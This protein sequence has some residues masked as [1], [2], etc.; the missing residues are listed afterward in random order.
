MQRAWGIFVLQDS[1]LTGLRQ[2]YW[3]PIEN[4]VFAVVK[5]LL[6]FVIAGAMPRYGIFTSWSIPLVLSLIPV[7]ILIFGRLMPQ[8]EAATA[9]RSLAMTMPQLM[10]FVGADYIGGLFSLMATALLPII[11]HDQAGASM[12]AYFYQP[13]MI[14]S[15]LQIVTVNL[16]A[17]MT[18]EA[19]TEQQNVHLFGRRVLR[20]GA[21]I[22]VPIVGVILI[23]APFLLRI[24]GAA[25]ATEGTTLLRLLALAVL[26][27]LVNMLF[28]GIARVQ[29]RMG[30]L[31]AIQ[32]SLC[33]IGLAL[34]LLL[35]PRYGITG[36]GIAWLVGQGV[37]AVVLLVTQRFTLRRPESSRSSD[38]DR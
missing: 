19:A 37:V 16:A 13:W 18:V 12:N 22:L 3:V 21:M 29:K 35:L 17:S 10:R 25:Y 28:I 8:H 20:H 5:L 24:F 31:I 9:D 6:L 7:N 1:T 32:A 27:N 14:A 4:A 2:A 26:P 36:I 23:G 30:L 11:V 33:V 15:S 34:S 38:H